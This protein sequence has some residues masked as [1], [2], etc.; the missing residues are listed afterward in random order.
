[1]TAT[2]LPQHGN[3]PL[4]KAADA[5]WV[6]IPLGLRRF[7]TGLAV[8]AVD[9]LYLAAKPVIGFVA[10]IFVFLLGLIIGV[11]HPGFDY[12]FTE[13]LWVIVAV[14]VIG[15]LSGGLGLYL[16]LGFVLGDLALG[17]HPQ[18][19][20]F[21]QT[22]LLDSLAQYGSMLLTYA[23]FAMLAVGVPVAAKSFA[24][25]FRLPSQTPR[26]LRALVGLGALVIISGLLVWVWT[27]SAPLLVRPVFVWAD[28]R[29]TV[30]AMAT[31]Q[32]QGRLIVS[33]AILAAIGRAVAQLM[34]ANPI[35][36]AGSDGDRMTQLENS[37]RTD[38]PIVPLLSRMRLV[39]RLLVR[40]AILTAVLAGLYAAMWQAV[41][42]FAVLFLAQLIASPLL[43]LNLG[44][45][46]RF[47]A[48]IPRIVRLIVVMIPMYLLGAILVPLFLDGTSFFPFL[49]LAIIAAV[50]MTLLSPHVR[51]E[52]EEQ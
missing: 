45:Y 13:A 51:E 38:Q 16:T 11:F 15:T 46:A 31:T 30:A 49:L 24:A 8:S 43:P 27:Q 26:A 1:M 40:A 34:L 4:S 3:D 37:F 28:F 29:P 23:L 35:G 22:F 44:G 48:R 25:E 36:A 12:V 14:A 5:I 21:G 50:L 42:A 32:V 47:M 52:G 7:S 6:G 41:L 33:L 2:P 10:P 9:G 20:R 19:D 39:V 17:D 18:W